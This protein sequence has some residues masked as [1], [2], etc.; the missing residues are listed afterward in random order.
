[1]SEL[2][3]GVKAYQ[4]IED[5]VGAHS[6]SDVKRH[7]AVACDKDDWEMAI[8]TH[9]AIGERKDLENTFPEWSGCNPANHDWS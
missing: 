9:I 2:A 3:D 4:S 6:A 1:M 8:K 5:F 7:Y